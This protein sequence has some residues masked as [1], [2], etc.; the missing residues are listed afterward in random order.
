[1]LLSLRWTEKLFIIYRNTLTVGTGILY[2]YL[3]RIV[4]IVNYLCHCLNI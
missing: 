1:M 4:F 3:K 2:Y